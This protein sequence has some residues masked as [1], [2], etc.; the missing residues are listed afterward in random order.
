MIFSTLIAMIWL[1]A[2]AGFANIFAS[3]SRHIPG[4]SWM[5]KPIDFGITID[6]DPLLGKNKTFRG[7]FFGVLAAVLIGV[8]LQ[9]VYENVEFIQNI[10]KIPEII[11]GGY[12]SFNVIIFSFLAGF[13]ALVGDMVESFFKRRVGVESGKP[14]F[15][16]DQIDFIIGS[17]AL[18]FAYLQISFTSYAVYLLGFFLLHLSIKYI[19]FLIGVEKAA[20]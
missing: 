16:F 19:G 6:G 17:I 18:T 4:T 7:L 15:P 14:W 3:M 9:L 10:V 5:A 20:I 12:S 13:G 11:E 8:G 2:P 1:F